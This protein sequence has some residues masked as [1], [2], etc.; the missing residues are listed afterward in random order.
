[1][2]SVGSAWSFWVART[3][4]AVIGVPSLH[5]PVFLSFTVHTVPSLE[6]EGMPSARSGMTLRFLSAAYRFG[7]MKESA[8]NSGTV[9]MTNGFNVVASESSAKISVPPF[10]TSLVDGA[11]VPHADTSIAIEAASVETR[12]HFDLPTATSI[13]VNYLPSRQS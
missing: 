4:S 2:S 5:L 6:T 8:R 1:M 10:F 9:D 7:Y 12:N 11:E 3:S 13:D